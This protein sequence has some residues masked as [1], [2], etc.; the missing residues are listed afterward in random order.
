[1]KPPKI[2]TDLFTGPDGETW[3][4]GRVYSLPVLASGVSLPFVMLFTG[5]DISL[6]EAG[7]L[8]GGLGAG[9]WAMI[10]GTNATEPTPPPEKGDA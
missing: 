7:V 2:V 4:I 5:R 6:A 10:S 9:V 8:L 1:M 3:A